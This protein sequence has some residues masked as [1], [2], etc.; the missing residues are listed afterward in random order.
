[1][2]SYMIIVW[3]TLIF[4]HSDVY[5]FQAQHIL[6]QT[7]S[8]LAQPSMFFLATLQLQRI[9]ISESPNKQNDL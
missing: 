2:K 7:N 5:A 4:V 3:I 8:P 9:Q 6:L 1:M